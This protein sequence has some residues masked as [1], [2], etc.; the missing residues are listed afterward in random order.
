MSY[1]KNGQERA[2]RILMISARSDLGGGPTHLHQLVLGLVNRMT[3]AVALPNDGYFYTKFEAMVGTSNI[4]EI[5]RQKFTLESLWGLRAFCKAHR[6]EIIHSHGKGAGVYSR[7]LGLLLGAPIVHTLHGYHDDRYGFIGKRIYAIWEWFAAL[8]TR[9]IICVSKSEATIFLN[10]TSV[11]THKISIIPNGTPTQPVTTLA[12]VP[13]KVVTVARFDY[14]KNLSEVIQVAKLLPEFNF[15]IIGDGADKTEI[16]TTICQNSLRNVT[17]CG[18]S[19][20]VLNDIADASLYLTTARWEGMPLAVLEAMSLGIPVL[21]SSV[22][23]NIDAVVFGITGYL[24]PLGSP[25]ACVS[26]VPDAIALNRQEI[27]AC[28]RMFFSS[29]IMIGRTFAV[30]EDILNAKGKA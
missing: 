10:K 15:F 24:Y 18:P 14:Q 17:L 5:P 4:F 7:F 28:H 2:T 29:E 23:G 13:N 21:A 22:V 25:E 19:H 26:R 9:Q 6:I 27:Q 20:T 12:P 8:L 3:V 11:P 16:E 1:T 30:Y